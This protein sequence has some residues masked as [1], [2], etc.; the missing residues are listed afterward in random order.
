MAFPCDGVGG[1]IKS[2]SARSSLQHHRMLTPAQLYSWAKEHF[3]S[4]YVQYVCNTEVEQ[5]RRH[6]K[7]RFDN[8]RTVVGTHQHH[9][10]LPISNTT[11]NEK[12]YSKVQDGFVVVVA[13]RRSL[14]QITPFES[15][16]GYIAVVCEDHWWLGYV[17]EKYEENEEFKIG[18][19]HPHGPS[20]SSCSHL[21]QKN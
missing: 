6:L 21:N 12:K 3:P 18:F 14:S 13:E 9:A 16:R 19:L 2:L 4:I 17:L 1:T 8:T 15:V 10:F 20:L 11:L 5:T 7:F